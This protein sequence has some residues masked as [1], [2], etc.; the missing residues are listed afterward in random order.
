MKVILV[1]G[2]PHPHGCTY[3]ALSEIPETYYERN[4]G[5]STKK[6]LSTKFLVEVLVL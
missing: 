4:V 2:S 1:N 3:T 6:S 5:Y